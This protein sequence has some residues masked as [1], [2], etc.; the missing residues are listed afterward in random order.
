MEPSQLGF[1]PLVKSWMENEF[2]S[3]LTEDQRKT[4]QV[5]IFYSLSH[6]Y[7]FIMSH[8]WRTSHLRNTH[9]LQVVVPAGR[10]RSG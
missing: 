3:N 7:Y 1:D 4:V 9:A 6:L 10:K 2:P 8:L 5:D